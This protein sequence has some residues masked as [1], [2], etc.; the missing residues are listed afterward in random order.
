MNW[1]FWVVLVA[2]ILALPGA[3]VISYW[4]SELR[5]KVPATIVAFFGAIVGAGATWQYASNTSNA[6]G[7]STFVGSFCMASLV[8][9]IFALIVNLIINARPTPRRGGA[10]MHE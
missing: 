6:D 1:Q 3:L 10:P 9:L 8:A 7:F 5:S 2:F 4:A